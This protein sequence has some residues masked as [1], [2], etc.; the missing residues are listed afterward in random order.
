[1]AAGRARNN[2][3]VAEQAPRLPVAPTEDARQP[4]ASR[5]AGRWLWPLAVFA[6]IAI[7]VV[8]ESAR[9]VEDAP[10]LLSG[11]GLG[12]VLVAGL[13]ATL[14][15]AA[16]TGRVTAALVFLSTGVAAAV[17]AVSLAGPDH[18]TRV[19]RLAGLI[20]IVCISFPANP[21]VQARTLRLAVA[22]LLLALITGGDLV[23]ANPFLQVGLALVA[24]L[25]MFALR[26]VFRAEAAPPARAAADTPTAAPPAHAPQPQPA[27]PDLPPPGEPSYDELRRELAR[28]VALEKQLLDANREAE[29]AMM[30]KGE[31]LATMSHEIR[32][33]LN[34]I[35]PLLDIALSTELSADQRDYIGTA[36]QSARQL[37]NIVDDILDYSKIEAHK[38]ELE[39]VSVDLRESMDGVVRLLGRSAEAKGL[40]LT[41]SM[42]P[43]VRPLVRGDP[44]RLRQVLTNLISNAIKFTE[45]GGV[46]VEVRKRGETRTHAELLFTV[47]DTG[48]GITPEQQEKLFEPFTQ[49]DAST[50]RLHGGTGLGL[51]ICKRIVELMGGNIGV[52]SEPGKG[53][54]FWFSVPLLKA[55]GDVAPSRTDVRG[56]RALL[57]S[58][59]QALVRRLS[60]AFSGWGLQYVQTSVSAEAMAKLRAATGM[61]EHRAFDFLVLDCGAMRT[62]ALSLARSVTRDSGLERVRVVMIGAEEEVPADVRGAENTVVFG[63][64]FRDVELRAGLQ[65]LLDG[66]VAETR[67]AATPVDELLPELH[68]PDPLAADAAVQSVPAPSAPTAATATAAPTAGLAGHVLLVE[69][70]VVNR[71]VAQRLLSLVGVTFDYAEHGKQALERLEA[72][73]YDLVLLDCMMP[74][75]DGY[76]TARAIRRLEAEGTR[77]GHIPVVAM[78]AN[79]MAGDREKCLAAGMDDYMSKPLNRA[80]LEQML[81]KWLPAGARRATPPPA[82]RAPAPIP[83]ATVIPIRVPAAVADPRV[84]AAPSPAQ[85]AA[86][87]AAILQDLLEMMGAEFTELVRVYLED[88]PRSL[89]LLERA[90]QSAELEGLVAPSHS[91]K[92]TSA[93]L[94]AL[95]L[96]EI[97]KRIEHGARVGKL[98]APAVVL[99]AELAAEYRRVEGELKR[100]LA[101]P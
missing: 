71:Q 3:R 48:M 34:G 53:S 76:A 47:T 57:F 39:S 79:A 72:G 59:D 96:A 78:T 37:L 9:S 89:A 84:A 51:V 14:T 87:N 97:A 17:F 19:L 52:K 15:G 30:A 40:K 20:A 43:G 10:W 85:G 80:V 66:K 6:L 38:L 73:R 64:Q 8:A 70:N 46:A 83:V 86:I 2:R 45:R 23:A 94:G 69:D 99:V 33:P 91:L 12:M 81:G 74:I 98:G 100:L 77:S 1:M 88:T 26:D 92:S 5:A 60:G 61:G 42:D 101:S 28:H 58:A 54:S 50:T 21:A 62:T 56:A 95:G 35:I 16:W 67:V 18:A 4:A 55:I 65:R 44:T 29:A 24:V 93:N 7:S 32:T 27:E 90:A 36:Y 11:L 49:A 22:L 25:A 13:A 75:L 63:R 82:S 31:F 41:A 68:A